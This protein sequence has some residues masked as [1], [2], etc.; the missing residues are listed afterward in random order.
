MQSRWRS[1]DS[2]IYCKLDSIEMLQ[3][4]FPPFFV[5]IVSIRVGPIHT[6]SPNFF[7]GSSDKNEKVLGKFLVCLRRA[8]KGFPNFLPAAAFFSL[9]SH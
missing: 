6:L 1:G 2:S 8:K 9:W 5:H 4:G 7:G 3:N